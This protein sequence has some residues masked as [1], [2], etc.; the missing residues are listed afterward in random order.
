[1]IGNSTRSDI[2]PVLAIGGHAIHVPHDLTWGLEHADEEQNVPCL[3]R[4]DEVLDLL[5]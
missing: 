5:P 4:L 2:E 1:M 3:S